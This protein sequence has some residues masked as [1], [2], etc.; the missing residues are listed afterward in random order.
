[1]WFLERKVRRQ[2][3]LEREW[4]TF[5]ALVEQASAEVP[6][7]G[8]AWLPVAPDG[9]LRICTS[10]HDWCTAGHYMCILGLDTGVS[11]V[12]ICV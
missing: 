8:E 11:L 5:V 2:R 1:M 12:L 6:Q 3:A 10:P 4:A 7:A 9:G